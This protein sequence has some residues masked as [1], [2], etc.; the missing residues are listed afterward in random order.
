MR[1]VYVWLKE[2]AIGNIFAFFLY[3]AS[4]ITWTSPFGVAF[5]AAAGHGDVKWDRV[6]I[7]AFLGAALGKGGFGGLAGGLIAY[8]LLGIFKRRGSVNPMGALSLAAFFGC[9]FPACVYHLPYSVYD[10]VSAVVASVIAMAACPA[11]APIMAGGSKQRIQLRPDEQTAFLLLLGMA[12]AGATELYA[13]LGAFMAGLIAIVFSLGG[14]ICALIG[15]L[16]CAAG[17][18]MGS[19]P[20]SAAALIF[21]ISAASGAVS[22]LGA[23]AQS[24]MF[25]IGVPL[26]A[27]FGF[28]SVTICM[29]LPAAIYPFIK[30]G[31]ISKILR[32]FDFFDGNR[33][34]FMKAGVYRRH[35]APEGEDVC[36]D[37]G[38]TEKLPRGKMLFLLA[39]GMGKGRAARQISNCTIEH[40]R[41]LFSAPLSGED[42]LKCIN[43]LSENASESHSTLDALLVDMITGKA[44]FFKNGA[45]PSWIL[46][47]YTVEQLE[48]GALPVGAL[49]HAP[50]WHAEKTLSP[51]DSVFMATDGLI[52]ALGGA[53]NAQALLMKLK[54]FAP[55]TIVNEMIRRARKAPADKQK[56]DMSAM[57]IHFTGKTAA[58]RALLHLP[59]KAEMQAK[60]AG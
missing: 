30:Q 5:L 57:L 60:K 16:V 35:I 18:L 8:A 59:K 36:G 41:Q 23:W 47:R 14:V 7:G 52:N 26:C 13:P 3:M 15:A 56:D 43:I 32:Y 31:R 10:A 27:Y 2:R 54:S 39:D 17:L 6:L 51:G 46:G 58:R 9:L 28:E 38:L 33:R 29:L 50:A 48:G 37:T 34:L 55:Q 12:V 24:A 1:R 20:P 11:I 45:E 42:A 49:M 22:G 44:E 4:P 19:A 53:E 25:L 21:L 40:A